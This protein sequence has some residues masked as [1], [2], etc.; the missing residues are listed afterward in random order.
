LLIDP[1]NDVLPFSS[2]IDISKLITVQDVMENY[3]LG[4]NGALIFCM[5]FLEKNLDWLFVEIEKFKDNYFLF[6][7][8]GQVF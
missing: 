2:S 1:G 4:P 7:L 6:D 5:E 8:P 3:N